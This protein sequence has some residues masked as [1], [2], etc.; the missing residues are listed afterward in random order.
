MPTPPAF[1]VPAYLE[2][3]SRGKPPSRVV[4]AGSAS[5]VVLESL[6][7]AVARGIARPILV[8]NV[9]QT[10]ALADNMD[11]SLEDIEIIAA[12]DERD[13]A[14]KAVALAR[15]G[16]ADVLMKGS[17]HTDQLLREVVNRDTG[18]RTGRRLSHIFHMT[19][20]GQERVLYITD[21]AVN[22]A[23]DADTLLHIVN[24]AVDLAQRLGTTE[25]KV[26]ILSAT[27]TPIKSMPS[28]IL[29]D[30]VSRRAKQGE[31]AGALIAGPL[32]LDLAISPDAAILK[33]V[34]DPVAGQADIL[35]VPNIEMGNGLFK[36]M[37]WMMGATAAGIV[38]GARVPIVLTSRAD[39][40]EARLA[41]MMI[42]ALVSD[43]PE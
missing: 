34:T 37:V 23:P 21:A 43:N 14:A 39:P 20:P 42:A 6:K 30:E 1:E 11:W 16:E 12:I 32:A 18:L 2:A 17:I 5:D 7:A 35:A 22:V 3:R 26:A 36:M 8:G 19:L 41:A 31:V 13:S 29:A 4:V 9:D 40:P 10:R 28:S 24:N 15:S 38:M 27:E 33:G 25:P